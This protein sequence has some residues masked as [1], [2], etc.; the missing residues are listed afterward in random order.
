MAMATRPSSSSR[1]ICTGDLPVCAAKKLTIVSVGLR[2]KSSTAFNLPAQ[3]VY[4]ALYLRE[5][6]R[7][8][9]VGVISLPQGALASS[10]QEVSLTSSLLLLADALA[11]HLAI[12]RRGMQ[13]QIEPVDFVFG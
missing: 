6:T 9:L 13:P 12:S 5:S 11:Y 7:I 2:M 3:V 8:R 1:T 4:V 10:K